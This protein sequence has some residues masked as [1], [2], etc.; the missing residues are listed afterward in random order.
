MVRRGWSSPLG[1]ALILMLL[2]S[3]FSAAQSAPDRLG[4]L[5]IAHGAGDAWNAPVIASVD[6]VRHDLPAAV[7][8]LMGHG[9]TPQDAYRSL[10]QQGATRI[11]VVPVLVSSHSAHYEQIRFLAGLVPDYPHAEH[12]ALSAITGP[13]PIIGVTPAMDDDALIADILADR[14]RALSRDAERE[15]LVLVAH[16]PNDDADA[17]VW[18]ATMRRLASR[19]HA[20]VPFAAIDARLLR[21]DAPKPVKD[22]ALAEAREAV[23]REG[24]SRRVIVI[25]QLLSPGQVAD[26]IPNTLKGVPFG[27]DGRTLFP[28]DR[29]GRW[30]LSR[31][32]VLE[33]S[34]EPGPKPT[35]A[36]DREVTGTIR[37]ST[38]LPAAGAIVVLRGQSSGLERT[39][40]VAASGRFSF[41]DVDAG[42]YDLVVG[43]D[44]FAPVRRTVTA[45]VR[46][47]LAIVL[48]PAAYREAVTVVSDARRLE[49][50]DGATRPVTVIGGQAMRDAGHATAAEALRGL[51]GVVTRRGSEGADVGGQQVQ[52]FDSR[53]VLFLLDGQ[54]IEAFLKID[55]VAE[56]QDPNVGLVAATG[57]PLPIYRPEVGCTFEAGVR[58]SWN[59]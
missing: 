38:G 9:P 44:G 21:D 58:W 33:T 13:V 26:E 5:V 10:V 1:A 43:L 24:T 20:V 39:N 18:L 23:T 17:E 45:P 2:C 59:R 56:S 57:T 54:P 7:G 28:D 52:G 51:A 11:V 15:A 47:S 41:H 32:R 34:Q 49:L 55:N 29:I 16:G 36:S 14:A 35:S 27:W 22:L 46:Q 3:S 50:R 42:P 12:M 6:A 40:Q 30:I 37:D 53:D 8:F 48:Q 4:V 25:P 19:I 31:A